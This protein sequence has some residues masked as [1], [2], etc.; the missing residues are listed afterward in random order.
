MDEISIEKHTL[1]PKHILLN[2]KEVEILLARYNIS[3]TQL[4]KISRKDPAIKHF[5]AKTGS[6]VKIVRDSGTAGKAVY[7]RCVYD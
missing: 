4:P 7:Y 3:I 1:V 2:E 5:D 6:I